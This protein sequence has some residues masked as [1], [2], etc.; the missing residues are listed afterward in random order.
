M[1]SAKQL[2]REEYIEQEYFFRVYRERLA[3]SMPSQEILTTV[4]E[5]IL[6]TCRLPVAIDILRTEILHSG[7]IAPAME[8]MSHYFSAFQSFVIARAEEDRSRFEQRIAL[9]IL[10]R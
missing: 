10:E 9:Q 8:R 2:D 1:S 4:Q 7:R 6:S 5:E 3:Q